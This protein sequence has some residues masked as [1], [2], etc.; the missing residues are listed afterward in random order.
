MSLHS[1]WKEFCQNLGISAKL[2]PEVA[3]FEAAILAASSPGTSWAAAG[4]GMILGDP[5]DVHE[6]RV[7]LGTGVSPAL[8]LGGERGELLAAVNSLIGGYNETLKV[9]EAG[10]EAAATQLEDALKP[11]AERQAGDAEDA[12]IALASAEGYDP[13]AITARRD[14]LM[15]LAEWLQRPENA[16]KELPAAEFAALME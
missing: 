4:P 5:V 16:N 12:A 8:N 14:T 15:S 9:E 13:A 11:T 3:E 6:S 7:A 10:A 1:K 2:D